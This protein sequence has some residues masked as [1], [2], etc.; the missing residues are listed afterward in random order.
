MLY[1]K[2][3]VL[4]L[5]QFALYNQSQAY[6]QENIPEHTISDSVSP[7]RLTSRRISRYCQIHLGLQSISILTR[8]SSEYATVHQLSDVQSIA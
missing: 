8:P 1:L 5:V 3:N 6:L 4:T 7:F 2:T